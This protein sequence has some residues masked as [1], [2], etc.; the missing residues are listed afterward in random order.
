MQFYLAETVMFIKKLQLIFLYFGLMDWGVGHL[1]VVVGMRGRAFDHHSRNG[2]R[3][4]C[5]R[6]LPAGLG[7]CPFFL[8]LGDLL[9]GCS[10]LKLTCI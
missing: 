1:T 2:G 6:K 5:Q 10:R 9:G 8:M 3:G 7:I 4:I